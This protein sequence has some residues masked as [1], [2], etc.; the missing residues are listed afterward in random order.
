MSLAAVQENPLPYLVA[1]GAVALGLLT[2]LKKPSKQ[3]ALNASEWRSFQLIERV[4]VSHNT[5]RFRFALQ[6]PQTTL[7]LPIGQHMCLRFTNAD[8]EEIVR[9]YTPTTSDDEKGYFDLVI[10]V[11]EKGQ[12]TQHLEHMKVGDNIEV[13]GPTGSITYSAR[14]EFTFASRKGAIVKNVKRIGMIAGGTGLTPMLQI[15]RQMMKD[16]ADNTEVSLIFA[17]VNEEDILLRNELEKMAD[18][19]ER[20][21]L[22]HVLNN[23]PAGWTQGEG[24]VNQEHIRANIPAPADDVL[25]LLC[26]PPPMIKAMKGHLEALGYDKSSVKAF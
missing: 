9:K 12:M 16:K 26:G 11:Y 15:A 4:D 3:V 10:K 25:V 8:G 18:D 23:P 22:Y 24:F 13:R 6:T 17:N 20:F 7:G 1:L 5:R 14:G 19:E 21:S 2:F